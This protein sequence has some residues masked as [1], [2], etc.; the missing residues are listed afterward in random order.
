MD[1]AMAAVSQALIA[2]STLGD[3]YQLFM[4]QAI[5]LNDDWPTAIAIRDRGLRWASHDALVLQSAAIVTGEVEGR[6]DSAIALLTRASELEPTTNA[7]NTLGDLYM[8]AGRYDS[9]ATVLRRALLR[10]PTVPGPRRRL[11]TSLE[12]LGRYAEAIQV[13]RDGGDSAGAAA[14]AQGFQESGAA[15]YERVRQADLT[16]QV[17][18]LVADSLR[19]YRLPEDTVPL[20]REER[21]AALYAQL[22]QWTRAMD[23]VERLHTRRSKRFRLFVTN[24]HFAGLRSDPRFLPLVRREGLERLLPR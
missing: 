15:G 9:A 5:Y 16:R 12:R 2:D 18:A 21:I 17:E 1:S 6:L 8:R 10:D 14:Y 3:P 22:G 4:S 20:L 11:I 13:R 7:L 24:P 19:P 23:W